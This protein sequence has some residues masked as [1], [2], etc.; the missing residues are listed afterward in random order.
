MTQSVCNRSPTNP[1]SFKQILNGNINKRR[2]GLLKQFSILTRKRRKLRTLQFNLSE[3]SVG[4]F[5]LFN[6]LIKTFN[7]ELGEKNQSQD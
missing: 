4:H 3:A 2:E 7:T 5:A 6:Y 1:I